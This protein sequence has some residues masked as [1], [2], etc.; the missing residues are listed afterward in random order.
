MQ[1]H[2]KTYSNVIKVGEKKITVKKNSKIVQ[3]K[4]TKVSHRIVSGKIGQKNLQK[5]KII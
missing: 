1:G 4:S 2:S 3:G 5:Q